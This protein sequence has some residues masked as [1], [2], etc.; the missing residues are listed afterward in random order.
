MEIYDVIVVG[1][2]IMGMSTAYYLSSCLNKSVLVIEQFELFH[3]FGGSHGQSRNFHLT[4]PNENLL[5]M[6]ITSKSLWHKLEEESGEK[7]LI[8]CKYITKYNKEIRRKL[9]ENSQTFNIEAREIDGEECKSI[10]PAFQP[11]EDDEYL[12]QREGAATIMA[13]KAMKA[14]YSRAVA[15]G[16]KFLEKSK[17]IFNEAFSLS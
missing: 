5:K 12:Y 1:A 6:T 8:P 9:V 3:S 17:V 14:L 2:G 7:I 16:A 11:N 15:A 10:F 13:S 4:N